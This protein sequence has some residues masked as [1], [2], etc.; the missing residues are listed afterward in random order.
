MRLWAWALCDVATGKKV[1]DLQG[2]LFQTWAVAFSPD[3]NTVAAGAL[4]SRIRLWDASTGSEIASAGGHRDWLNFLAFVDRGK[5]LASASADG[6]VRQWNL[7]TSE[8][9]REFQEKGAQCYCGD[10][11]PDGRTLAL[12][13]GEGAHLFD[14]ATGQKLCLLKGHHLQLWSVAFSPKGDVLASGGNRDQNIILWDVKAKK[15]L[16]RILTSYWGGVQCL[17]WSPSGEVLASAGLDTANNICL[18][19]PASGQ[20]IRKWVAHQHGDGFSRP[21]LAFSPDG[22]LLA[23]GGGD[24]VVGL[25]NA[26]TGQNRMHL[27]GHQR[28]VTAVAFSPDGRT[29]ASGSGDHTVRL[30]E[31]ATGKER[32]CY[33]GHLGS[34][35]KLTFSRDGSALA[36]ASGDTSVL[37]WSLLGSE[38]GHR[39][40]E[41]AVSPQQLKVLWADLASDDARLAWKAACSLAGAP[42]RAIGWIREHLR[43]ASPP[44]E[45]HIE[46][47]IGRLDSDRFAVRDQASRD[48]QKL[49]ALAEPV[50]VKALSSQPNLES[51]RRLEDLL[52]KI[53]GTVPT[54]E[55]LRVLR[56]VELLEY[57]GTLDARKVLQTVANGPSEAWLTQ[58]AKGSLERLARRDIR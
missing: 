46:Q 15:E 49:G 42:V 38:G 26:T 41:V 1:R 48:L 32:H 20:E 27:L 34:I 18:W 16:R 47:L 2:S 21:A 45:L 4:D 31:L 50:L 14:W 5:G 13:D 10:L 7:A 58:Q 25:W 24:K 30:W 8:L 44:D 57:I 52:G 35:T 33:E 22:T 3:G 39:L 11:S 43:P 17:A 36:S 23:T 9:V 19:D 54:G 40:P 53:N 29:L 51:R 55:R 56:A 12:G 6:L 28:A 37:V